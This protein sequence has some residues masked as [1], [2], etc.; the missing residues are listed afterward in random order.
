M[1]VI[2]HELY[3]IMNELHPIISVSC[4]SECHPHELYLIINE[5]HPIISVSCDSE[6]HNAGGVSHN[7]CLAFQNSCIVLYLVCGVTCIYE[8]VS[9]N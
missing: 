4:D 9:H 3:L 5:L 2:L 6:C 8:L 7:E 1:N